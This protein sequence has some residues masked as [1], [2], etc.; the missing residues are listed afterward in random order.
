MNV[1]NKADTEFYFSKM[2]LTTAERL[3]NRPWDT[4]T[5]RSKQR[6]LNKAVTICQAIIND[7]EILV[8]L[9]NRINFN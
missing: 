6:Y 4:V 8:Q 3:A 9:R 1:I 2:V 7:H 5:H